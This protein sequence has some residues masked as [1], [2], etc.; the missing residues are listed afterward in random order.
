MSNETVRRSTFTKESVQGKMK[1][2][3]TDSREGKRVTFDMETE[4]KKE[5]T[6]KAF[7]ILIFHL[8]P[9]RG[10]LIVL[11]HPCSTPLETPIHCISPE[12]SLIRKHS[13]FASC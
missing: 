4:K 6:F 1:K 10:I 3:P 11:V 8:S 9:Q 13:I 7:L 12:T 2:I 5:N